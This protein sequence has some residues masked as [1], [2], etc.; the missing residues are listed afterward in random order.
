MYAIE[1]IHKTIRIKKKVFIL[2]KIEGEE[3]K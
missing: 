2:L 3:F 1:L